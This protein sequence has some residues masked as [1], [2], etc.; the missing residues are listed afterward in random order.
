[1]Q[2]IQQYHPTKATASK[3]AAEGFV[4]LAE[5]EVGKRSARLAELEPKLNGQ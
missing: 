5:E 3:Q 4:E 2:L 1:M